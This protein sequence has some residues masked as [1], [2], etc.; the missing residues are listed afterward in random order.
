M[1]NQSGTIK[2]TFNSAGK[3]GMQDKTI[4]LTS[5]ALQNP[6]VIHIKGTVEKPAA[7]QGGDKPKSN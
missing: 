4:T 6:M 5:N 1:K 2:V 7:D 3:A